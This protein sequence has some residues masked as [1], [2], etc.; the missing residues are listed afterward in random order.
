VDYQKNVFKGTAFINALV[1]LPL[2]MHH[3][4]FTLTLISHYMM[5][6]ENY[7]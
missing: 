6:I 3:C 5:F 4:V 2:L 1:A 7:T